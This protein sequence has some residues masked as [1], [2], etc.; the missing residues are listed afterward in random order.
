MK[1][2]KF[3]AMALVVCMIFAVVAGCTQKG[4]EADP[5]PKAD[6]ETKSDAEPQANKDEAKKYWITDK[7]LELTIHM[8]FRDTMVYKEDWLVEQKARELTNI[9]LKSVAPQNAT[10]STEVF[11]IMMASGDLADIVGKDNVKDEFF[12]YGME[13]AFIPLNDLIDKHAPNLKKFLQERTDVQK[14]ITAPDGNIYFIPY[15]PD[16]DAATGYFIRQD[17]LDKLNLQ[18]PK[19]VD[20]LYSVLKAFREQDPNE[21]G[22]KDEV[23]WLDRKSSD[24]KE[25]IRLVTLWGGHSEDWY[26]DEN[27]KVHFSAAEPEFK[28]GMKNLAK[29]YAEG[30][31]DPEIYT[32]GK[33][34]REILFGDNK[35]G[36]THDWFASTSSF[37]DKLKDKIPGF[38]LQPIAPP[39]DINGRIM[40]EYGRELIKPDGWAI[41]AA[42]KHPVETIKYF[43]FWFTEEGRRLANF[44]IEGIHYDMV[45]GKPIFKP[46]VLNNAQP[47]NNQMWEIGAQIPRGF[48]QD[49]FYE[50]QWMNPVAKKGARMYMDNGYIMKKFPLLAYTVEEKKVYD[51]IWPNIDTYVS[52]MKQ[53]WLLGAEDV[54]A[55]WDK[56][57]KTLKE[58]GLDELLKVQ[59]SAYDRYYQ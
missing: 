9:Y 33:K 30:I 45:D 52:E 12:Q 18:V 8:H 42:N 6:G 13:G 22:E 7:P 44:G 34:A 39:A 19:T 43:D 38:N 32:R 11:N 5:V 1:L 36:A 49:F 31:I 48:W 40:E 26:E 16:G 51:R 14:F 29:W 3:L 57:V 37:N 23:P 58:L 53:K 41:S 28:E 24:A 2:R 20:E 59:Q 47:V 50:E 17:W 35:G 21:N 25:T 27:G 4:K 46:E 55:T 56:H 54:E 15:I 10:K